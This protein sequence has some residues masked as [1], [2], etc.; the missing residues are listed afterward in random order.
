MFTEQLK[1]NSFKYYFILGW[2]FFL[3]HL[4]SQIRCAIAVKIQN[5]RKISRADPFLGADPL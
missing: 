5:F 4:I 2:L 1:I 3:A